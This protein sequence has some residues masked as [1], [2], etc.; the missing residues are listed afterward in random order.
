MSSVRRLTFEGGL[1]HV[2]EPAVRKSPRL[3]EEVP[4]LLGGHELV[5]ER[6][7]GGRQVTGL[8][9]AA[10]RAR[11]EIRDFLAMVDAQARRFEAKRAAREPL[12]AAS[13]S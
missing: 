2:V 10:E 6:L 1:G 4:A 7:G 8:T 12:A 5:R 11:D 3:V 13:G 9:D